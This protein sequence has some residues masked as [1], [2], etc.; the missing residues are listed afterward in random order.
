[1]PIEGSTSEERTRIVSALAAGGCVAPAKEAEVLFRAS[2]EGVGRIDELVARR[3]G[4]EPLAWITGSVVFGGVRVYVDPGVFVPRPQTE[5]MAQRAASLLPDAG[6]AVDLCTGSGAVAAV[7]GAAHPRA[8][9]V[10]TEIDPIAVAC[11]R[12][13]GVDVLVG[14][15]DEPLPPS[16]R[17]RVDV[18]TAVVP[19][20]PT[21]E[22]PFLPRDVLANEPRA[23]LDGGPGGTTL[24]VRAAEAAPSWLKPGG[25][26]LLELGGDQADDVTAALER[27]GLSGIRVH[28]DGDGQ[29]RAI[30]A[31]AEP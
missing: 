13:N 20:V 27:V 4:G 25:R 15:L 5:E 26:V 2:S 31:R 3:L 14:D 10:A 29:D 11:A 18:M 21:E 6:I 8:S 7:L 12:R 9:V 28:R 24:L 16:I 19:Y 23:A 1:M 22:L 30:E 17:G